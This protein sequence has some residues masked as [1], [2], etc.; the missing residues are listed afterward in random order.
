VEKTPHKPLQDYEK[1]AVYA[2]AH[3]DDWQLFMQPR[4]YHD[5]VSP[6]CKVVFIITT[7]GDAGMDEKFWV[8]R[9]EGSK[10]SVRF[11]L[12]PLGDTS[13]EKGTRNFN[14]HRIQYWSFNNT[15]TYFLRL[16]DGSVNGNGFEANCFN[17]LSKFNR[18][19]INEISA[20]DKSAT[21]RGWY[22]LVNVLELIVLQEIEGISSGIIHYL[23]P[24]LS[25]NPG[26]HSDHI[27]TGRAL[28]EM[29]VI[30]SLQQVLYAGY[31]VCSTGDQLASADLFFKTGMFAAYEK[32][33]YDLSGYST[34]KENYTLYKSW[35][36]KAA[37]F[38]KIPVM[39]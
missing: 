25:Y 37:K 6:N 17:C 33:V 29:T 9:E 4:V 5:L 23:N 36:S 28:Q 32:A 18:S 15:T 38:I 30:K 12:A 24:D 2:V 14:N 39:I 22:E 10:S 34:L 1:I 8:A 31:S 3:A 20:I 16:P 11:C 27:A 21:Y 26:D 35:C 19:E 13:E 7:A